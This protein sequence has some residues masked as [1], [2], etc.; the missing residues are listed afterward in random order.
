[1]KITAGQ[2]LVRVLH[3][4][5]VK[6]IYGIV[7][8][9]V[10]GLMDALYP[11]RDKV[12][13]IQ[14]RHEAAGAM[15]AAGYAKFT[16]KIGV[17]YGS[18]APGGTNLFNGLYDAKMDRVPLLAIVGQT[19]TANMNTTFFQEMDEIPIYADVSVYNHCVTTAEQIPNI[20]EEAIRT[21]YAKNGVSVVI[22]PNDLV[23]QVIDYTPVWRPRPRRCPTAP[24]LTL[25]MLRPPFK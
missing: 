25:M 8:S 4:W 1:M 14:V 18:A 20:I 2:A 11:E 19:A 15:A 21:A 23:E 22:L 16:R 3:S 12:N 7:G 5:D 9:S 24:P 17:C 13:Y 10:N 6:H